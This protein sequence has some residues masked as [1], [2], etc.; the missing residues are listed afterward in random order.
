MPTGSAQDAEQYKMV[1]GCNNVITIKVNESRHGVALQNY[2]IGKFISLNYDECLQL[3]EK[4]WRSKRHISIC[5]AGLAKYFI[6]VFSR[7][8]QKMLLIL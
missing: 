2:A 5:V 3:S 1:R 7:I 4:E 6:F 8:K